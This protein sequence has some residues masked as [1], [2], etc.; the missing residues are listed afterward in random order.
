[1]NLRRILGLSAVVLVMAVAVGFYFWRTHGVEALAQ[2]GAVHLDGSLKRLQT[3]FNANKDKVR[4]LFIVGPSCGTCLLG[5]DNLNRELVGKIQSDQRFHTFVVCVPALMATAADVPNAMKVMSG[6]NVTHYW[7]GDGR[8]GFAYT[9]VLGLF[10]DA[11][12]TKR[13]F[14]WDVWMAYP[15]GATWDDLSKPPAPKFWRHQLHNG[16]S[17]QELDA[18]EFATETMKL[19]AAGR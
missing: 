16:P 3:D 12:K 6:P 13:I 9:D 8:S 11:A 5:L 2:V 15:P 1:M 4:L 18:A 14:A 7:D 19:A 17:G 10:E